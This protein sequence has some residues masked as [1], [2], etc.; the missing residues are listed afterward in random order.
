MFYD[1]GEFNLTEYIVHAI[2]N[3]ILFVNDH[4]EAMEDLFILT[5]NIMDCILK[6]HEQGIYQ[7]DIKG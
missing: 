3:N 7:S 6:L 4:S 2:G 1:C 5:F